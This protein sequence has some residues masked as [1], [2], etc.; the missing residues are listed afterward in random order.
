MNTCNTALQ[1]FNLIVF[2]LMPI[3]ITTASELLTTYLTDIIRDSW[4]ILLRYSNSI[5]NR[6]WPFMAVPG[7]TIPKCIKSWRITSL[8]LRHGSRTGW[9]NGNQESKTILGRWGDSSLWAIWPSH[10]EHRQVDTHTRTGTCTRTDTHTHARTHAHTLQ[11]Y[12]CWRIAC[13]LSEV[14]VIT[15]QRCSFCAGFTSCTW[16]GK[17]NSKSDTLHLSQYRMKGCRLM[18]LLLVVVATEELK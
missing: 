17:R 9:I 1:F 15:Y 14:K 8:Y 16:Q 12:R 10:C 6:I 11:S 4:R 7:Q 2:K 5:T 18:W 13:P 3:Q